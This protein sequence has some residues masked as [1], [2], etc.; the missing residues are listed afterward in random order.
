MW[1]IAEVVLVVL[2]AGTPPLSALS[3]VNLALGRV[4]SRVHDLSITRHADHD[5]PRNPAG[6][7]TRHHA[8]R[9]VRNQIRNKI[10]R[11][12]TMGLQRD[13]RAIP[14]KQPRRSLEASSV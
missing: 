13:Q 5:Q 1:R 12:R 7:C 2:Y 14:M 8:H 10:P 4:L 3:I 11:R 9:N 6:V